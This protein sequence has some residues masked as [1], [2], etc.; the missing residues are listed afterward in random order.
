MRFFA[1]I[2]AIALA[3]LPAAASV[4][5]AF[6]YRLSDFSGLVATSGAALAWDRHGREVHV[7]DGGMVRI[8]DASGMEVHR[9][10]GNRPPGHVMSVAPVADGDVFALVR[11]GGEAQLWRCDF[12]GEPRARVELPR[13]PSSFADGF[14][15]SVLATNDRSLHVADPDSMRVVVLEMNGAFR[16]TLDLATMIG[17]DERKRLDTGISGFSVDLDGNV[18]FT[19]SPEFSAYV[20]SP[21]GEVRK[22]GSPGSAPGRFNVVGGIASDEAGNLF[23]TDVLRSVVMV[24]DRKL[25]FLHEFGRRGAHDGSLVQPRDIVVGGGRLFVS[26]NARRGVSVFRISIDST[27]RR[28]ALANLPSPHG[29]ATGNAAGRP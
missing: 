25:E 10:G 12:R 6:L 18:L 15:P 14:S 9:Y 26:Q 4:E 3:A 24:F 16:A 13:L 2:A 20:V 17:F 8:F 27:E 22:F 28:V 7:V 1:S 29:A 11:H 23:V 21:R 19:I 5:S